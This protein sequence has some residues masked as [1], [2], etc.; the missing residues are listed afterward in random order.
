MLDEMVINISNH[1]MNE[2]FLRMFGSAIE[3]LLKQMFGKSA[4]PVKLRGNERDLRKLAQTLWSEKRFI[5]NIMNR[6]YG[7][8]ITRQ[9]R[10]VLNRHIAD[11]EKTTNLKWPIR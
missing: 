7:D 2:S 3:M 6:G 9:D 10:D 11:F 1:E 5:E 8:E 4:V